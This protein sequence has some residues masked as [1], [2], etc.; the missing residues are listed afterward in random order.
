MVHPVCC[1]AA[2]TLIKELMTCKANLTSKHLREI[3]FFPLPWRREEVAAGVQL[4]SLVLS[5]LH[6]RQG[7][8]ECVFVLFWFSLEP[9]PTLQI[10]M[11]CFFTPN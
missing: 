9:L 8:Q 11:L 7:H 1:S 10:L 6:F 3:N 2:N 5:H 4:S